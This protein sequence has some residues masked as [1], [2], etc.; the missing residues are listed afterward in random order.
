[1]VSPA[2]PNLTDSRDS[3]HSDCD[4]ERDVDSEV[5]VTSPKSNVYKMVD[6]FSVQNVDENMIHS[7][8]SEK[9]KKSFRCTACDKVT[10]EV[11]L[12]PLL[13][14]QVC[15]DCKNLVESIM[16]VK[17][18]SILL[19]YSLFSFLVPFPSLGC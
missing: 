6:Q 3:K 2:L 14:V 5:L 16:K 13:K 18:W 9:Q 12:H 10:W 15:L 11:N 19:S 4:G 1:M 7:N 17:V 8:C